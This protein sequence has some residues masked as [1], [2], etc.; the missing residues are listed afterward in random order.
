MKDF[1]KAV[2]WGVA[3]TVA[4]NVGIAAG[5]QVLKVG[6]KTV[7]NV[8]KRVEKALEPTPPQK[9][10]MSGWAG[11]CKSRGDTYT[12]R[13]GGRFY[14]WHVPTTV[15]LD[16]TVRG[17]VTADDSGTSVGEFVLDRDGTVRSVPAPLAAYL[18]RQEIA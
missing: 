10:M 13:T 17:T 6:Q 15:S 14:S 18:K 11:K 16:G 2:G 8:A 3:T 1:F 12:F 4:V 7:K 9:R 5:T